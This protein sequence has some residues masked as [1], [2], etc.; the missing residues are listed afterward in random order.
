MVQIKKSTSKDLIYFSFNYKYDLQ[1]LLIK[2]VFK[3]SK[4]LLNQLLLIINIFR[5]E[6]RTTVCKKQ[7]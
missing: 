4:N 5:Y 6:G 7:S 1:S 3:C 2:K